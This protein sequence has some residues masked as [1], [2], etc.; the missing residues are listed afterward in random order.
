MQQYRV[1]INYGH[2]YALKRFLFVLEKWCSC[3]TACTKGEEGDAKLCYVD[4]CLKKYSKKKC[5]E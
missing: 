1:G 2:I 5:S 3:F 4:N